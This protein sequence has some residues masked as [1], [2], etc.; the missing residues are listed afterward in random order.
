LRRS[1]PGARRWPSPGA[2]LPAQVRACDRALPSR[3]SVAAM[4]LHFNLHLVCPAL[5]AHTRA[6]RPPCKARTHPATH[7]GDGVHIMTGPI[8][9]CGAEPGDILQVRRPD[10]SMAVCVCVC[11][12]LARA[13]LT[14]DRPAWRNAPTKDAQQHVID[15]SLCAV[16]CVVVCV[17]VRA[18]A[19]ARHRSTFWTLC[20]A[21]T[22]PLARPMAST[23]PP[24][25]EQTPAMCTCATL[26]HAGG[27]GGVQAH[28]CCCRIAARRSCRPGQ[29]AHDARCRVPC[30]VRCVL[31]AVCCVLRAAC[32]VL[33]AACCVLCAARVLPAGA[34]S[35]GSLT[36]QVRVWPCTSLLWASQPRLARCFLCRHRRQHLTRPLLA[37]PAPRTRHT[38]RREARG[39]DH[40]RSRQ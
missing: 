28:L 35:G 22:P 40:L 1:L 24:P 30:A 36:R 29:L 2:V 32:C 20:R 26:H 7:T 4:H 38:H 15:A 16:L 5:H 33:H 27:C 23:Q 25:G 37:L 9:V 11:M 10:A 19:H 3:R 14:V 18:R 12:W 21:K 6:S 17:C 39:G 13:P 34:T 31:C 8:Y